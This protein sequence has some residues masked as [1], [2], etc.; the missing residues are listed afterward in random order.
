MSGTAGVSNLFANAVTA[1]GAQVD[2][3]YSTLV[4]YINDPT[5]R[6]N[7]A[8]DSGNT[9]TVVLTFS[10]AVVGGYTTGLEICFKAGNTNSGATVVNANGLGNV[11]LVNPDGSALN[12]AQI[13]IGSLYDAVYD[14]TRFVGIGF[15]AA[16]VAA[17]NAQMVTATATNVFATP[18]NLK[19]GPTV[20]K[21]IGW[22]NGTATGTI[23][24]GGGLATLV[25]ATSSA[26]LG[27]GTFSI[28]FTTSF[29]NTQ[30]VVLSTL[31]AA[32]GNVG[33]TER[34]D[35]RTT[36]GMVLI[37]FT[38]GTGA[39]VDAGGSQINFSVYGVIP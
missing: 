10:P 22:V 28:S 29:S 30:F 17:T 38:T 25:G 34:T 31:G 26:K 3:N 16:G 1:T 18:S 33:I 37:T 36:A 12:S 2:A 8:L 13:S 23:T 14:G 7:Y 39:A 27:T 11:S 9:N 19:Y 32:G 5:N 20:P 15:Q 35:M 6:N 21:V 24:S 4:A